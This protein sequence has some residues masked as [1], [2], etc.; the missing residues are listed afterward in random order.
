MNV[1]I[2]GEATQMFTSGK[3]IIKIEILQIQCARL[4][5]WNQWQGHSLGMGRDIRRYL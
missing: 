2:G 5:G 4:F 3:K 1:P